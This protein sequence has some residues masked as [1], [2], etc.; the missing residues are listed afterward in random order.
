MPDNHTDLEDKIKNSEIKRNPNFAKLG[1]AWI[2]LHVI[3]IS[4]MASLDLR[5]RNINYLISQNIN[6][7]WWYH[8][9]PKAE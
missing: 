7:F 3:P 5:N 1:R 2:V 9:V 4:E 8:N 6:H